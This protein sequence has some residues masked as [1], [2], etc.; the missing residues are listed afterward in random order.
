MPATRTGSHVSFLSATSLASWDV[1][2]PQTPTPCMACGLPRANWGWVKR[3]GLGVLV[4]D[5]EGAQVPCPVAV[6]W[7]WE[8]GQDV[9]T[10]IEAAAP[11]DSVPCPGCGGSFPSWAWVNADALRILTHDGNTICPGDSAFGALTCSDCLGSGTVID[12]DGSV[13]GTIGAT[14]PCI[15]ADLDSA[16]VALGVAA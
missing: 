12:D 9:T 7:D 10:S 16:P 8:T 1:G 15:C 14:V 6:P 3:D 11:A 5:F 4:H 2:V 13:S